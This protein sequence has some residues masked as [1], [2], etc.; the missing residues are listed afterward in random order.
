MLRVD[1]FLTKFNFNEI[2]V[3]NSKLIQFH[4]IL[5]SPYYRTC[6]KYENFL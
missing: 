1:C 6:R 2:F 5:A 3:S 4:K